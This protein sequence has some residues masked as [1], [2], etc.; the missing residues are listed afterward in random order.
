MTSK[1][2]PFSFEPGRYPTSPGCYL[3]KDAGHAVIYVGKAKNLRRRLSSYFSR[4]AHGKARRL[5]ARVRDIEVILV[6]NE[7]ESLVLEN[8]L[9]KRHK[10][11]YNVML[12]RDGSG[13]AYIM[14]T[15][16]EF[17]RFVIYRKGRANKAL[18]GIKEVTA[19]RRFGPFV[20]RRFRDALLTFVN[21]YFGLRVC[22]PL[23]RRVCLR[24]DMGKCSGICAHLVTAEAYNAAVRR[25]VALLTC[26]AGDIVTE[27]KR[28]MAAHAERLEFE[29]AQKLRDQIRALEASLEKQIV[30]RDVAHDQDA[31]FFGDGKVMVARIEAGAIRDASLFDLEMPEGGDAELARRNFLVDFYCRPAQRIQAGKELIIN[32]LDDP[33]AAVAALADACGQRVRITLPK[34]GAK[35]DLLKLCEQNYQYRAGSHS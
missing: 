27:L 23:P 35:R 1:R 26:H 31:V 2:A 20:S 16:E 10:P 5:A 13:Y 28:Q 14:L 34:R 33:Q 6:N 9:I 29:K 11:A 3:M 21:E 22:K 15:G 4:A 19:P 7:T 12:T 24:Y 25:A 30:D 32:H 18:D 17:P 8:N